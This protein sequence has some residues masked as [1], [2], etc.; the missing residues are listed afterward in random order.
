M[1]YL[2]GGNAVDKTSLLEANSTKGHTDF[3]TRVDLLIQDFSWSH[4]LIFIIMFHFEIQCHILLKV[5]DLQNKSK[6]HQ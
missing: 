3:P 2:C 4:Q 1:H 6:Y 5:F